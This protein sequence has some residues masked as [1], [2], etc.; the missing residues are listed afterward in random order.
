M[1]AIGPGDFTGNVE[2]DDPADQGLTIRGSASGGQPDASLHGE[3]DG[4]IVGGSPTGIAILLGGCGNDG[5]TL[6]NVTVDTVGADQSGWRSKLERGSDLIGVEATNQPGSAAFSVVGTCG[7]GSV[8]QRS[9]ITG[10]DEDSAVFS[11]DGLRVIESTLSSEATSTPAL[12]QLPN[13]LPGTQ[14][15]VKRSRVIAPEDSPAEAVFGGSK[16]VLDSSLITGGNIGAYTVGD[17]DVNN[18][19]IDPGEPGASPS[20]PTPSMVF[21]SFFDPTQV[22]VESSILV[23]EL[24]ASPGAEGQAGCEFTDLPSADETTDFPIDCEPGS[25]GNTS[26]DPDDL[27]V[28]GSPYDWNL[29][30]TSPAIDSG[31]PGSR[32]AERV[33]DPRPCGQPAA[34]G[35][36]GRD[37]P[38]RG[39][40]QG[41][42]R[43]RRPALFGGRPDADRRG[44]AA[45]GQPHRVDRRHVD[46]LSD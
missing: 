10:T 36:L 6:R 25:S 23:G 19:T 20:A 34:G 24:V 35:R 30:P 43:V 5:V 1:I 45:P 17:A 2:T 7:R 44:C 13:D 39:P 40:R 8:I 12:F 28:G 42:L 14:L 9:T 18:T 37:L 15:R 4:A 21:D 32:T 33:C 31:G 41:R 16:L 3:G 38:G 46:E 27:F 26:T 22:S 11:S 29:S